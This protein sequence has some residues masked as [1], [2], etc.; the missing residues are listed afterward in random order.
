MANCVLAPGSHCSWV[1]TRRQS[2]RCQIKVSSGPNVQPEGA[3]APARP[4]GR[5]ES[6]K[7]GYRHSA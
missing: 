4:T 2:L 5:S 3:A 1:G 6:A 7:V